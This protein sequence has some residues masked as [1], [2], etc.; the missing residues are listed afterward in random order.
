M[1]AT[2]STPA[3]DLQ[4]FEMFEAEW[5]QWRQERIRRLTDRHGSQLAAPGGPSINYFDCAP[6]G[7][8]T[9]ARPVFGGVFVS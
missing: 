4:A 3:H 8:L 9:A 5:R 2:A 1:S 7:L 6:C